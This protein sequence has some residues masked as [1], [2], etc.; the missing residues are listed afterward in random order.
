MKILL[1]CG[2]GVVKINN[3]PKMLVRG[4]AMLKYQNF[5]WTQVSLNAVLAKAILDV[6]QK[7]LWQMLWVTKVVI[8]VTK[9]LGTT[10]LACVPTSPLSRSISDLESSQPDWL[11]VLHSYKNVLLKCTLELSKWIKS[12]RCFWLSFI[13]NKCQLAKLIRTVVN[14]NQT[15]VKL[16]YVLFRSRKRIWSTHYHHKH[17]PFDETKHP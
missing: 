6:N 4:Q 7:K 2:Q 15:L 10:L 14:K 11:F 5:F 17:T 16:G 1:P 13:P 3:W 12:L 9:S 8:L